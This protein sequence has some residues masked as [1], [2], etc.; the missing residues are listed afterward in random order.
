MRLYNLLLTII[1]ILLVLIVSGMSYKD[2]LL[3]EIYY[4]EMVCAK[5]WPDHKNRNP[6]C[7]S[8]AAGGVGE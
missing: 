7:N 1:V 3:S 6:K 4:E 8:P 5:V 2:A